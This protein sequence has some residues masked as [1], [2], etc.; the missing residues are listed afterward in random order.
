MIK[1]FRH[2]RQ[3]L[4]M[5]NKIGKYLKYAIGE[6]VLVVIGILIALQIN[7]W[8]QKRLDQTE[9]HE[10]LYNLRSDFT[11]TIDELNSLNALR[12]SMLKTTH[13]F[14]K[15]TDEDVVN[16][17]QQHLDSMISSTL[18]QPTYNNPSETLQ[19]LF[20]SG[21]LNLIANKKLRE[22]LI[23]WP[24]KVDDMIEGEEY[25]NEVLRNDLWPILYQYLAIQDV[26]NTHKW[27]SAD[28]LIKE[29]Q[30]LI[31]SDYKGL[32]ND[33]LFINALTRREA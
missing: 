6:I 33:K 23:K 25:G 16:Y 12:K 1:F 21:K 11:N 32:F 19:L 7:N 26:I 14:Y 10:I 2:I 13:Q 5:E 22:L 15:M 8:N 3:H 24:A 18:F 17:P 4:I 29:K 20:S 30:H 31:T 27:G 9:V 28:F